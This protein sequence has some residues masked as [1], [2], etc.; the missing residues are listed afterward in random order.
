MFTNPV[1]LSIILMCV[2]CL[3]RFN[4]LLSILVSAIFAG[5]LS[6][7]NIAHEGQFRN[8]A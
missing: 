4:V 7:D 1:L 8:C 6:G 2:L 5:F 3:L